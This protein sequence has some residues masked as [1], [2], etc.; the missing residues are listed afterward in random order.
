MTELAWSACC[1]ARHPADVYSRCTL[2]PD[3]DGPHMRAGFGESYP[4]V[5]WESDKGERKR[6]AALSRRERP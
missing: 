4:Y 1:G 2:E 5:T 3:H 6:A